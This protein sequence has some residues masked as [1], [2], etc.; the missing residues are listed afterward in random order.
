MEAP[1]TTNAATPET[2]NR[3]SAVVDCPFRGCDHLRIDGTISLMVPDL[4]RTGNLLV[5]QILEQIKIDLNGGRLNPTA[6][7]STDPFAGRVSA[8]VLVVPKVNLPAGDGDELESVVPECE[9]KDRT[10]PVIARDM[11]SMKGRI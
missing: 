8:A 7:P 10:R 11:R 4:G 9:A 5:E 6:A 3:F 1:R 2:R